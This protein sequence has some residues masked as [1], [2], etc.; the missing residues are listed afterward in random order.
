MVTEKLHSLRNCRGRDRNTRDWIVISDTSP[1]DNTVCRQPRV[2][3]HLHHHNHWRCCCS[4]CPRPLGT[5]P[6]D[7]VFQKKPSGRGNTPKPT[8]NVSRWQPI[9]GEVLLAAGGGGVV[10]HKAFWPSCTGLFGSTTNTGT[11]S[12]VDWFAIY[13]PIT[14][15]I[16]K[17]LCISLRGIFK[18]T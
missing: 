18:S 2:W 8:M 17:S 12:Q 15:S 14:V 6:W 7:L 3:A 5:L 9:M 16:Q 13:T 11:V 4:K 10:K 1:H